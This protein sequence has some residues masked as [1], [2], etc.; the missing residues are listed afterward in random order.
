[1]SGAVLVRILLRKYPTHRLFFQSVFFVAGWSKHRGPN[2]TVTT[3]FVAESFAAAALNQPLALTPSLK[4]PPPTSLSFTCW[5]PL[6][7]VLNA[8]DRPE[9][10]AGGSGPTSCSA[11]GMESGSSSR[12]V[13]ASFA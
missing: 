9:D 4:T 12:T 11:I 2:D 13:T 6:A 3:V 10:P 8:Q 5:T 7:F 1:M